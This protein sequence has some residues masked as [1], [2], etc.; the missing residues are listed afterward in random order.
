MEILKTEN[1]INISDKK[2]KNQKTFLESTFNTK[3][4]KKITLE[5]KNNLKEK[6]K[7]EPPS[8]RVFFWLFL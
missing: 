1:F 6:Q 3:I 2:E 5:K 7:K 4:A 8:K